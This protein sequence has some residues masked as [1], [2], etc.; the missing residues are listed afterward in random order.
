MLYFIDGYNVL[1]LLFKD[2]DIS[3]ETQRKTLI[4][5]FAKQSFASDII[6]VFD[7]DQKEDSQY[8]VHDNF[9]IIYTAKN[10]TADQYILQ[11]IVSLKKRN[12]ITLVT[13]DKRLTSVA[14][15]EGAKHISVETF[16]KKI[17]NCKLK[18]DDKK[19][20][21]KPSQDTEANIL[22]LK[23]AFEERLKVEKFN[24]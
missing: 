17:T 12:L 3:L 14:T 5:I 6:L 8:V 10:E 15:Y 24:K 2:E 1:F 13:S 11:R 16:L 18:L 20:N 4:Q 7:G 22:R 9:Q 23:K 21:T 19:A